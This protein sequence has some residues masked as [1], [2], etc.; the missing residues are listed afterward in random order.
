MSLT[1][2]PVHHPLTDQQPLPAQC[3]RLTLKL[4][5]H[6]SVDA[7]W[8]RYER[9]NEEYLEPL[10]RIAAGPVY[11]LWQADI[12]R[13]PAGDTTHYVFKFLAGQH[14]YWLD[15]GGL[16]R[17]VPMRARHFQAVAG[18]SVPRWVWA[19][20]FY[21]VFPDRFRRDSRTQ[22][23]PAGLRPWDAL[24]DPDN[25][26]GEFF[27]GDLWGVI[28]ALPYLQDDLGIT[29]LYLNPVFA[30]QSNHGYD[31]DDYYRIEPRLGGEEALIALR[32][33]LSKRGMRFLLDAV[34]NHTSTR[35]PWFRAALNGYEDYRHYYSFTDEG[36]YASWKGVDTLPKLNYGHPAVLAD[37]VTGPDSVLRHWLLPPFSSDGWRLDAV[38]MVGEGASARHNAG[39]VRQMRRAIKETAPGAFMLGEHFFEAS[40]WLQGDQEDGAMNYHGFAHPVRAWLASRDIAGHPCSLDTPGFAHWLAA[41]RAALPFEIQLSQLNLLDSHDTARFLTLLGGDLDRQCLALLLL[42]TYIGVPCL[43][44]GDEIGLVGGDDPDCRRPFPWNPQHWQQDL[45]AWTRRLIRLRR[46]QPALQQ[47]LLLDVMASD[48][49]FAFARILEGDI[50]LIL[51]NRGAATTVDLDTGFCGTAPCQW[52]DLLLDRFLSGQGGRLRVSLAAGGATVLKAQL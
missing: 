13:N 16:G 30:S 17:H 40:Q 11:G 37:M 14:Q 42:F 22:P 29:A 34:V 20:V 18:L 38:H 46:Q 23:E 5:V 9:D 43:Y 49:Q 7:A 48:D 28:E 50:L 31:I 15:A 45:L 39:L 51:C 19:Q 27:G 47:G 21:Q 6:L 4:P 25:G 41:A 44:Y 26:A 36:R 52:Q 12:E 10:S 3:L 35:H 2:W 33:A 24:P 8:V 32:G 1:L